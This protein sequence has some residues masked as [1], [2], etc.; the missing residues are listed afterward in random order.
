[1]LI[2]VDKTNTGWW[3]LTIL[4][5]FTL[6]CTLLQSKWAALRPRLPPLFA[7]TTGALPASAPG[8]QP[9][10]PLDGPAARDRRIT[11]GNSFW[12]KTVNGNKPKTRKWLQ[13]WDESFFEVVFTGMATKI[14]FPQQQKRFDSLSPWNPTSFRTC[15]AWWYH[16]FWCTHGPFVGCGLEKIQNSWTPLTIV[17]GHLPPCNLLPTWLTSHEPSEHCVVD[18]DEPFAQETS[19]KQVLQVAVPS[20]LVVA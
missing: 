9:S 10:K 19:K 11:Q 12:G 14:G 2:Y 20:R 6:Y 4:K 13:N 16:F 18:N 17:S 1:M 3:F 8:C 15:C 7:R 5:I